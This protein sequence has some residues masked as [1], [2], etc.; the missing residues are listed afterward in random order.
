MGR[1]QEQF[2]RSKARLEALPPAYRPVIAEPHG[3]GCS[4]YEG[5]KTRSCE[6][7][8]NECTCGHPGWGCYCRR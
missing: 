8:K 1:L 4:W 2:E 5:I 7:H 6:D 3:C